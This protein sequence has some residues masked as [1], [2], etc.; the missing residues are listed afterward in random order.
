MLHYIIILLLIIYRFILKT[1]S[2]S[3]G[4]FEGGRLAYDIDDPKMEK[5][6]EGYKE[7]SNLYISAASLM[8]VIIL[9]FCGMMAY[10]KLVILFAVKQGFFYTSAGL[11][12]WGYLAFIVVILVLAF[13]FTLFG[14]TIP[15]SIAIKNPVWYILTFGI[16]LKLSAAVLY[17][18]VKLISAI[19][20]KISKYDFDP[21]D[22]EIEEDTQDEIQQL[23]TT[24]EETGT[25]D[26]D[27]R[28]MIENVFALDDTTAEDIFTHRKDLVALP[29]D[30]TLEDIKKVVLYKKYTRIPVY[31]GSIDNIIGIL[32]TKDFSRYYLRRNSRSRFNIKRLLKPTFYVPTNK[33][34][35]EIFE[36]M[37]KTKIHLAIV[38]DE[39]GGTL[40]IV[41]MEDIVEEIVGEI[42]DEYDVD[43]TPL[44]L[45]EDDN[46]FIIDGKA[47]L[48]EVADELE[49]EDFDDD[50]IDTLGGYV[51]A[52]MGHI[53][54][55]ESE[56]FKFEFDGWSFETQ[57]I[58]D[59][60]I[61]SIKASK[62]LSR[63]D[64]RAQNEGEE[65]PGSAEQNAG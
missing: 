25:I 44:I 16:V 34:V 64:N 12:V 40:G 46:T 55:D 31:E 1:A 30:C 63:S 32:N 2:S 27:E 20:L 53:P 28:E 54:E 57:K 56:S 18:L 62:I 60:R 9:L 19:S 51:I 29:S 17:P 49:T 10:S 21:D 7:K 13:I 43:E 8:S 23:L 22:F 4:F 15:R 58:E 26:E 5:K 11:T 39:Y 6:L 24:G 48:D 65:S 61:V 41:T 33:K 42:L 3:L 14:G 36:E 38:V 45:K 35:D 59:K 52:K 37:Q 50:D 47:P